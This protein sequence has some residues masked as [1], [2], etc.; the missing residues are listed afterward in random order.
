MVGRK[1]KAYEEKAFEQVRR[2]VL[3]KYKLVPREILNDIIQDACLA[4][5]IS[6]RTFD[7]ERGTTLLSYSI[8][9]VECVLSSLVPKYMH[10]ISMPRSAIKIRGEVRRG[11]PC[12]IKSV[13]SYI[14]DSKV[15]SCDTPHG[16]HNNTVGE[17]LQDGATPAD[18]SYGASETVL[19]AM[20]IIRGN[21]PARDA[22]I[23]IEALG[24]HDGPVPTYEEVGAKHGLSRERVRQIK[25]KALARVRRKLVGLL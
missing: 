3:K 1:A 19:K 20:V 4:V 2:F 6:G 10:V 13:P 9:R 12:R 21:L 15:L 7:P 22:Q 17:T 11:L 24:L 14:L 23:L 5:L 18:V 25:N 16:P 8:Y